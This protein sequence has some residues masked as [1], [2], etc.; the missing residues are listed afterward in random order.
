MPLS[1]GAHGEVVV[2]AE[3]TEG[4]ANMMQPLKIATGVRRANLVLGNLTM[5]RL[6]LIVAPFVLVA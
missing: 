5:E 3:A 2:L 1:I 4:A 6:E